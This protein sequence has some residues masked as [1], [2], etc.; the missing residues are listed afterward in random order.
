VDFLPSYELVGHGEA[1]CEAWILHGVFGSGRNWWS[2]ARELV[3]RFPAWRV[4]LVDLRHHGGSQGASPPDDLNAVAEDVE[5]LALARGGPVD[6]LVGHSFGGKVALKLLQRGRLRPCETWLMDANPNPGPPQGPLRELQPAARVLA[7]LARVPWPLES[8]GLAAGA[9]EAQGVDQL[10]ARWLATSLVR[11]E[12]GFAFPFPIPR[13]REM[14][15]S[16]WEFDGWNCLQGLGGRECVHLVMGD[17]SQHFDA[18][19]RAAV[20]VAVANKYL[21]SHGLAGAGHWLQ[22][23]QP[24]RLLQLLAPSLVVHA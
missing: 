19:A 11:V 6:L 16:Y 8:R 3:R 1:R 12:G 5:R 14:L 24:E 10:T 7:A 4:V 9:L 15:D 17:E 13:L 22:A 23:D 21:I 18:P 20:E 2:F